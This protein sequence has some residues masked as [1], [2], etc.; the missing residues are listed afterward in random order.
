[1]SGCKINRDDM[2]ITGV[3]GGSVIKNPPASAGDGVHSLGR[4]DTLEEESSTLA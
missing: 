1:M 2:Q 4:E 3:P